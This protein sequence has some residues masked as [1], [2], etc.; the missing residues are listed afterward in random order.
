MGRAGKSRLRRLDGEL[1]KRGL[2]RSRS[3]ANDLISSGVVRVAGV[4]TTKPSR[5]VGPD[6]PIVVRETQ[7]AQWVSRGANKLIGALD[8]F[9]AITVAKR[10]CLDAGASTGGFTQVLLSRGAAHVIAVDVGYGQLAWE[11]RT[12]NRITVLERTNVRHLSA[13]QLDYR[14]ELV[15]ADLS[16]I[17]LCTVLPAL[18]D[19]AAPAADWL[20]MV[21][22]QFEVGRGKV[23]A[24]GVVEDPELRAAAVRKVAAAASLGGLG[25][26]GV[27]ASPLPGPNGNVE[28]FLWLHAGA[29]ELREDDLDRAL[30]EGPN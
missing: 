26:R 13:A 22:P 29:P 19:V 17:S 8:Y 28:Y 10:L 15:V 21:K 9:P 27:V 30:A 18:T 14:A 23:G 6:D 11:L 2:A 4:R 16:F 12:D 20:L 3:R 5:Q 24:K 7:P 25:V 1:V